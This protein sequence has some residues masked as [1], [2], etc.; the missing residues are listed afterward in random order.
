[1]PFHSTRTIEEAE[2]VVVF[3]LHTGRHD[4]EYRVRRDWPDGD[5]LAAVASAARQCGLEPDPRF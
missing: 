4:N 5:I 2:H 1:V 3:H